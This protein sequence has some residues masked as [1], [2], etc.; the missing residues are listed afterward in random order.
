MPKI[1]ITGSEGFIGRNLY[2]HL[3]GNNDNIIAG[4]TIEDDETSIKNKL[5]GVDVVY[6]LAGINRP[7]DINEFKKGNEEFTGQLIRM[8]EEI[9]EQ[10]RIVFSSSV[11]AEAENPYGISKR[12]AEKIL[13]EYAERSSG[14]VIVY[15]L[16]NVFGKWSKPNYNSVVSTFCH[17][18]ARD[19]PIDIHDPRT[20]IQLV[21]IDDV[22]I[23][24]QRHVQEKFDA[25]ESF[26]YVDINPVFQI[27]LQDLAD[28]VRY[29][30]SMRTHHTLPDFSDLL[31]KYLYTTYLS[32]LHSDDFA[33]TPP[34]KSDERGKLTELI[35]SEN[36]GQIFVS[37]TRPGITRGN[38]YH[39][40]KVEKFCVIKGEAV[41]RF[42]H[43]D[44]EKVISYPVTGD[45][46]TIVDIPPGYTHNIEN[47]GDDELI[48][49]FWANEK[50]NPDNPDTFF[51]EV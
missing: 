26:R 5:Q 16:P 21:Y 46:I 45:S 29:F 47:T 24:F 32:Y 44:S 36:A 8:L 48:V 39:H 20:I 1:A 9:G 2:H 30:R 40:T 25:G 31:M 14:D 35:K 3:A 11:Q 43:I 12:N 6:H 33:Y 28:M 27:T 17:N 51:L 4:I 37:T 15:R 18:I 41:I 23:S 49:M 42:R 10:P 7:D 13:K 38:H 22:V 19:L 50:F 34:T